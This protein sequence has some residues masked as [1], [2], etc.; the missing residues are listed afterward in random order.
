M[1]KEAIEIINCQTR[2][3]LKI[4]P[5]V[6]GEPIPSGNVVAKITF[7]K[8]DKKG[9]PVAT[10]YG[11]RKDKF[12]RFIFVHLPKWT[13][14]QLIKRKQVAFLHRLHKIIETETVTHLIRSI[15]LSWIPPANYWQQSMQNL[16]EEDKME[17]QKP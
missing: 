12:L 6:I 11:S 15:A 2:Q 7:A 9:E 14:K 16:F 1:S 17:A 4:N 8:L 10:I 3:L 13:K 5:L